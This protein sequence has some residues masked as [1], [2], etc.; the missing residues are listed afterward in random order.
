MV[1]IMYLLNSVL[2][3]L[4]LKNKTVL[5]IVLSY[6]LPFIL[7]KYPTLQRQIWLI[8]SLRRELVC[9]HGG[10]AKDNLDPCDIVRLLLLQ[11][12]FY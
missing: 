8:A 9:L 4:S 2:L 6:S 7:F 3:G 1:K 11:P 5:S 12:W 10:K